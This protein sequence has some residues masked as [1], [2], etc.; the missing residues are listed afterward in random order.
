MNCKLSTGELKVTADGTLVILHR[1]DICSG[2]A[3][4]YTVPMIIFLSL[5]ATPGA[6]IIKGHHENKQDRSQFIPVRK[7]TCSYN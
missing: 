1:R 7:T 5:N 3:S 6:Y 4:H 2:K